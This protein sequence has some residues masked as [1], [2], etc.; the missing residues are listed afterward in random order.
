MIFLA[1]NYATRLAPHRSNAGDIHGIYLEDNVVATSG[2]YTVR[3]PRMYYDLTL[4]KA[5]VLDAVMYAWSV[6]QQ[7]PMYVRAEKL[8]QE[9]LDSW[10][11]SNALLTNS[12]F[13]VP[14][15]AIG[16]RQLTIHQEADPTMPHGVVETFTARDTTFDV[17]GTPIVGWPFPLSGDSRVAPL[18]S[19]SVGYSNHEGGVV[20]T[21]WD[22]F[23]LAGEKKPDGV[24]LTGDL[25]FRG[26]DGPALGMDLAYDRPTLFGQLDWY[27]LPHDTGF[28]DIG[29]RNTVDF[30]GE[31]RGYEVWRHRQILPDH[32]EVS[33]EA[34]YVSDPLFLEQYFASE[35]VGSKQYETSIY[36][37]KQED[38]SQ[39]TFLVR[40]DLND[41]QAQTAQLQ[42]PGYSVDRLPELGYHR[43]GTSF[44]DDRLTWF[45]QTTAGVVRIRA[46]TDYPAQRGFNAAQSEL[47][48]G[49]TPAQIAGN[50]TFAQFFAA[51]GLPLD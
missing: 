25:D 2:E 51:K 49:M 39:F 15:F 11:G 28:A 18:R 22:L 45:E 8:R 34:S 48:F 10:S 40:R 27:T 29:G 23:A 44:W 32:W 30:D 12:D 43:I 41:F 38:D 37:K 21:N 36:V 6:R 4:N 3:A 19:A 9:S 13:A 33:I 50:E 14:V 17:G 46:G 26:K 42:T 35:A 31:D 20:R 1:G 47:L 7:I 24:D 16:A 5:V